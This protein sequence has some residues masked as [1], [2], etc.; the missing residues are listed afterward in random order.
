MNYVYHG[1]GMTLDELCI[2]LLI[3]LILRIIITYKR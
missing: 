2:N 1:F 3:T